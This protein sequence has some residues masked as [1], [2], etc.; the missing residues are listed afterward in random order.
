MKKE[1]GNTSPAGSYW[2]LMTKKVIPSSQNKLFN[3]QVP[4]LKKPYE[5]PGALERA[6]AI[7][8]Y[9]A[10]TG[11]YSDGPRIYSRCRE[12]VR[13]DRFHVLVGGFG[14]SGLNINYNDHWYFNI[15]LSGLRKF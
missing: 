10:K 9:H 2:V 11:L 5:V 13:G 4:L 7:L 12:K 8:M 6:T 15:G 1:H 14:S 3:N